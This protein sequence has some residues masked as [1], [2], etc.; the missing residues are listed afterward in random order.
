MEIQQVV[1]FRYKKSSCWTVRHS[2]SLAISRTFSGTIVLVSLY[3]EGHGGL[4][5]NV[6]IFFQFS[7]VFTVLYS[8]HALSSDAHA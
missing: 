2:S 1:T 5:F 4:A 6:L 8:A 3:I 7:P